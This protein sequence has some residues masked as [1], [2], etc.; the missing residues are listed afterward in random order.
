ME[1]RSFHVGADPKAFPVGLL[2][3]ESRTLP[4]QN[5]LGAEHV[6]GMTAGRRDEDG[7]KQEKTVVR[8]ATSRR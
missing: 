5:H 2:G 8:T 6:P 4:A 7:S 1:K 3:L